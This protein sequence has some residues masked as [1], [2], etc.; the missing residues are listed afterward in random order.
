MKTFYRGF[1]IKTT[2]MKGAH[3]GSVL[4][5]LYARRGIVRGGNKPILKGMVHLHIPHHSVLHSKETEAHALRQAQ[6]EAD[7]LLF[8]CRISKEG[9]RWRS[10]WYPGRSIQL[11]P[12][13]INQILTDEIFHEVCS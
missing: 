10:G 11:T 5:C 7:A 4:W 13:Q 3:T 6:R 12:D 9:K 1:T 8:G 2:P